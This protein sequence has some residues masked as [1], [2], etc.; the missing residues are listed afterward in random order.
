MNVD[1]NVEKTR[2]DF[3]ILERTVNGRP[4]VYLDSGASSQR[5]IQVI[6]AVEEIDVA[7]PL[8]GGDNGGRERGEYLLDARSRTPTGWRARAAVG[9]SADAGE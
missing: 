1:M 2:K 7:N 8:E 9:E 5:P 6:R 4:L 3:P